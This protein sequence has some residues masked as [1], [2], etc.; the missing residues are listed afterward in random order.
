MQRTTI[1]SKELD[2]ISYAGKIKV[3]VERG[4]KTISTREYHNAGMPNLFKFLCNA[5]AGPFL[6]HLR[7]D[8]KKLKK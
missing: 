4:N 5:L 7:P 8:K 1:E 2:S 6:G 3:S